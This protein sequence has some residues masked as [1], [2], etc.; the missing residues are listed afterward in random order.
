[1]IKRSRGFTLIEILIVMAIIGLLLALALPRYFGS[2]EH[3]K[4]VTLK[5]NL[6]TLRTTLDRYYGDRGHYPA[7]L[8]D[9]VTDRY[10]RDIPQDPITNRTDTWMTE[11]SFDT[12]KPGIADIKSGAPGSARDGSPYA[13]W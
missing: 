5:E 11:I 7:R 9:L 2:L 4:E 12:A 3:A 6:H 1:M 10:L 13:T 8:D